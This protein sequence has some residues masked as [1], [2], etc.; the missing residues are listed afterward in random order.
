MW[1]R[2]LCTLPLL[3]LAGCELVSTNNSP[4]PRRIVHTVAYD[5]DAVKQISSSIF[6]PDDDSTMLAKRYTVSPSSR[7]LVRFEKL[8]KK[9]G[10]FIYA[11]DNPMLVHIR[12]TPETDPAVAQANLKV[13][14]LKKTWM[15]LA[16]W[17]EAYPSSGEG[18][19][20]KRG[21]DFN[22]ARCRTAIAMDGDTLDFDVSDWAQDDVRARGKNR[23]LIV[24]SSEDVEIYGDSSSFAPSLTW[25]ESTDEY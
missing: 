3:G 20:S 7:V 14:P 22:P 21:G 25:T 23:G 2:I 1:S 6:S 5:F 24:I 18:H 4:P 11:E 9:I 12:I 10:N 16:T 19:W 17:R 13:C 8:R 15:M